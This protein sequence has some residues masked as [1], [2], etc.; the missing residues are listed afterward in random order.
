MG[1]I[2]RFGTIF[3][4]HVPGEPPARAVCQPA[5]LSPGAKVTFTAVACL[6][7]S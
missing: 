6:A 7:Q 3:R 1:A 4:R 5:E 2:E